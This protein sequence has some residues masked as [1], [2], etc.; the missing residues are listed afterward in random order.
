MKRL[1][2]DE[3]AAVVDSAPP[4]GDAERLRHIGQSCGQMFGWVAE[5]DQAFLVDW[6]PEAARRYPRQPMRLV[7]V[8]TFAGSTARG[9]ITLS[10]GGSIICIDNFMDMNSQVLNHHPDG[11]SYWKATIE[12]NGPDYT[13]FAEL[14]VGDSGALGE[15]FQGEIDLGFIDG[16]HDRASAL[17]DLRLYG[18]HIV[19]G[20]YCLVDDYDM[21]SV[22]SA[23]AEY[24][25]DVWR[26]VRTP[27]S[28]TA[29][30]LV[31]Q[32]KG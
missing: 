25:G 8:G 3:I 6:L 23:C 27:S 7:E 4:P 28:G 5:P 9:L 14:R 18:A 12:G 17:R 31:M 15:V 13:E 2:R 11:Q 20:G 21:P 32:R 1:S 30:I 24:F 19:P 26:V 29:K 16:A 22:R 10:R